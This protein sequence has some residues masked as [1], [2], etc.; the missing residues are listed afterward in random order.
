MRSATPG[1]V[2]PANRVADERDVAQILLHDVVGHRVDEIRD[3]HR[4]QVLGMTAAPWKV[5]RQDRSREQRHHLVPARSCKAAPMNQNKCHVGRLSR[6]RF[7]ALQRRRH[8]EIIAVG[9]RLGSS[10][11]GGRRV[12]FR[13]GRE[14]CP[15]GRR[16][17]RAWVDRAHWGWP[18]PGRSWHV[19]T[20]TGARASALAGEIRFARRSGRRVPR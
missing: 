15:C 14:G 20:S 5:D 11:G 18:K 12:G 4:S 16:P 13:V 8:E 9:S 3:R 2:S 6:E 10:V 1:R 7:L 17:G 19:W